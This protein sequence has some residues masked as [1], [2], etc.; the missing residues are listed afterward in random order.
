LFFLKN[1]GFVVIDSIL[2]TFQAPDCLGWGMNLTGCQ[3]ASP[4]F[5]PGFWLSGHGTQR[6]TGQDCGGPPQAELAH[7]DCIVA[8]VRF[9]GWI[10]TMK[11]MCV[12]HS[13]SLSSFYSWV[14]L[15]HW[16]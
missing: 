6:K 8:P 4:T 14:E 7:S 11:K 13:V 12:I 15:E 16:I 1:N 9:M 5:R 3:A 2:I 10:F